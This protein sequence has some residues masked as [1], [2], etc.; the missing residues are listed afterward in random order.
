MF[1][2]VCSLGICLLIPLDSSQDAVQSPG[3]T[4]VQSRDV[5]IQFEKVREHLRQLN[6]YTLELQEAVQFLNLDP[7]QSRQLLR[8]EIGRAHV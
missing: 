5:P 1:L 3:L 7:T 8:R 4:T 6:T 2:T